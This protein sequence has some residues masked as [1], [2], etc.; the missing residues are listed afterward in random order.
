MESACNTKLALGLGFH[1]DPDIPSGTK[2][3]QRRP[4]H[5][6]DGDPLPSLS[7]GLPEAARNL[8]VP[9][10]DTGMM[11]AARELNQETLSYSNCSSSPKRSQIR[12]EGPE[13][14]RNNV[15][16]MM[17]ISDDDEDCSTPRKKLRLSKEQVSVLEDSFTSQ[18]TLNQKQKEDLARQ[19]NLRPRQVEVWFQNRRARIKLKQTEMDCETLKRRCETLEE[20]NMRLQ[21]ELNEL[22]SQT[23]KAAAAAANSPFLMQVRPVAAA[24]YTV[25]CPSCKIRLVRSTTESLPKSFLSMSRPRLCDIQFSN[26]SAAC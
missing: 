5:Q 22:R 9:K 2:K 18:S 7:L 25:M 26:P 20:E 3:N 23:H 11:T 21:E 1:R 13:F 12:D 8:C 4:L 16:T 15:T 17:M 24:S 10:V 19:L 14:E 6:L